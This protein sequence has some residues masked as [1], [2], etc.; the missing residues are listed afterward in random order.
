MPQLQTVLKVRSQS[1]G[2][3]PEGRR[4]LSC[5]R[6]G[7]G[8]DCTTWQT[9]LETTYSHLTRMNCVVCVALGLGQALRAHCWCSTSEFPSWRTPCCVKSISL[10]LRERQDNI[11]VRT[12]HRPAT[13]STSLKAKGPNA[14]ALQAHPGPTLPPPRLTWFGQAEAVHSSG[15]VVNP[16]ILRAVSILMKLLWSQNQHSDLWR[17]R[18]ST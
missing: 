10:E 3:G 5:C 13:S 11:T 7:T 12:G 2:S 14:T 16:H 9:V 1:P 15:Q 18:H 6:A 4:C 8:N 17:D